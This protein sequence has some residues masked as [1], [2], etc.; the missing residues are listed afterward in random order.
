MKFEMNCGP[1]SD[2]TFFGNPCSLKT[3]SRYNVATPWAVIVVLHGRKYA[4]F[5][6]RSM[7]TRIM[8]FPFDDINGP[9]RSILI[10]A[11][12]SVGISLGRR[13]A[14]FGCQFGLTVWHTWHAL[15]YVSMSCFIC[16]HQNPRVINSNVLATPGCPAV[17]T[18]WQLWI[19][20]SLSSFLAGM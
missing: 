19:T 18:S 11:H 15:I 5:E 10:I 3:L 7:I 12:G 16:G 9:M 14:F 20:F 17:G 4:F 8:S 2:I 1:R 13:G 6:N